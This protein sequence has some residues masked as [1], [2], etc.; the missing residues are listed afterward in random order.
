MPR[1]E[2]PAGR[3]AY[4]YVV[5]GKYWRFRY[6][7]D[8]FALP[9]KPG[10]PKFE[11]KYD[12]F[13]ALVVKPV[14]LAS[15]PGRG[16]FD[17]VMAKFF[18]DAEFRALATRTQSNYHAFGKHVSKYLGD[19]MMGITTVEMLGEVRNAMT[20]GY[21]DVLRRF[22][23]RLYVFA[24]D[25]GYVLAGLNP[26]RCLRSIKR[27]SKKGHEPWSIE[28]INLMLKHAEGAIRTLIIIALCTGQRPGDVER[29]EWSQIL[30][31]MVRVRQQKTGELMTIPAHPLLRAEL[32]RLRSEGPV[33]GVIVRKESGGP[34]GDNGFGYRLKKLVRSIPNMPWRTPHGSRYA[35]AGLL[36]D[37]GCDV[38]QIC[39]IIGHRTYEM[40]VKYFSRRKLA[41]EAMGRLV[42]HGALHVPSSPKILAVAA[43]ATPREAGAPSCGSPATAP[44]CRYVEPVVPA[45]STCE[46]VLI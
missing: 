40:A 28:E 8:N 16:T 41:I 2:L 32:A 35:T 18:A 1:L 34:I 36:R 25:R 5:K 13:V 31:D 29:M 19:C 27:K 44:V 26:A 12:E 14:T 45:V 11:D 10:E 22:V 30:D 6:K 33:E 17:W 37:A 43:R 24:S 15:R 42:M 46:A 39:S 21:A 23:S 4:T 7:G 3:P 9:G 38:D 20:L